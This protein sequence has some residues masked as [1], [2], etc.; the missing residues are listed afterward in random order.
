MSNTDHRVLMSIWRLCSSLYVIIEVMSRIWHRENLNILDYIHVV[1]V[2]LKDRLQRFLQPLLIIIE[3]VMNKI[4][5]AVE[6]ADCISARGN[7]P[8]DECPG[9]DTKQSDGEVPVMLELWGMRSTP[10]LLSLPGQLWLEVV[11]PERV[12]STGRIE[13]NCVLM[14]N[15]IV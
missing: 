2:G 13:L 10:S 12:L 5:G 4:H 3:N 1:G 15:W 7:P 9:Y 8:P 14:L 6:Y 11:A